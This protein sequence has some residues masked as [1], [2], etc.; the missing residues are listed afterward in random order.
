[1]FSSLWVAMLVYSSIT[2][3]PPSIFEDANKFT[4]HIAIC[5][6][7]SC[8]HVSHL[9]KKK[10]FSELLEVGGLGGYTFL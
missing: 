10:V 3:D 7:V 6:L 2:S 4:Q 1:M 5:Q 9:K 8:S